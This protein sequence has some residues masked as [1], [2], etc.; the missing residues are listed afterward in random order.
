MPDVT[1]PPLALRRSTAR[2]GAGLR[3]TAFGS[4]TTE[5][6]GASS[7]RLG[8]V[9]IMHRAMQPH[10]PGLIL[11][12]R[13]IGGNN[14]ND[15]HA[16]LDTVIADAPDLVLLQT[17][18]NDPLQE[19]PLAHFEALTRQD[20]AALRVATGAD[21][22]LIDQQYCRALDECA[23]FPPFLASLHRIGAQTAT[24]VFP[25]HALM[26]S[27]CNR[28]GMDRDRLSPDG[29]HMGDEGYALL[30]TALAGW[31]LGGIAGI[32]AAGAV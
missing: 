8:F 14:A 6:I 25:R 16:R 26:R 12:N 30:G 2:Q 9:E 20:I 22:V 29:L 7:P 4:S 28:P 11:R 5:G 32:R 23:A 1:L 13:G 3:I 27:W 15:L 17:G 21:I 18:S 31:L 24:P 19:V 10:L